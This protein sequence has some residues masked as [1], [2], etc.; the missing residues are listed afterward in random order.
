M[1]RHAMDLS[2]FVTVILLLVIG[3]MMVFSSSFYVAMSQWQ[4][5]YYFFYKDLKFAIAGLIIMIVV[6]MVPYRIYRKFAPMLLLVSIALLALVLTP[7]GTKINGAQ[8]WLYIGSISMMPSEIAKISAIIFTAHSL[9]NNR[10]MLR[11]FSVGILPYIIL[12]CVYFGLII[13]QP[14][15]STAITITLIIMTMVFVAGA[16]LDQIFALGLA[17]VAAFGAFAMSAEYRIAR[18]M[19]FRNPFDY[20][21]GAGWQVIQSLYALGSGGLFGVGIGQSIQNK[22]YIPEPQNDFIFATVGEEFGFVGCVVVILL[23]FILIYRGVKIA[24]HAP[25]LFGTLISTGIVAMISFQVIIN[26]SVA[27]S[28]M[29]VTGIPLPFIS[30]GGSS[31]LILMGCMGILLNI[32]QYTLTDS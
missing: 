13:M 15:L 5:K 3:V 32:S 18:I 21:D 25:D 2:L 6:A 16:R 31:L 26:I 7:V 30:F 19:A 11:K 27:T 8:R 23:F 12:I 14:N 4:D 17:G 22:L 29:P 9:T 10:H 24:V 28:S 1:K 20:A